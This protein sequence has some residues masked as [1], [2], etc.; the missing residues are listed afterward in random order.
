MTTKTTTTD[1]Q[2]QV[3]SLSKQLDEERARIRQFGAILGQ[4]RWRVAEVLELESETR[5]VFLEEID[6]VFRRAL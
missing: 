2:K 4:M 5:Q 3:D 1:L 6:T